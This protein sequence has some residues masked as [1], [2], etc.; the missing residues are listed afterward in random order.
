ML[1]DPAHGAHLDAFLLSVIS[2]IERALYRSCEKSDILALDL[3]ARK[4]NG[5]LTIVFLFF[6][7]RFNSKASKVHRIVWRGNLLQR[8]L[9]F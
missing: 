3:T 7:L 9:H 5:I 1:G 8:I 2:R 6:S 4:F